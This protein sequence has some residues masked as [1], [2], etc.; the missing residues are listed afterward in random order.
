[1][2]DYFQSQGYFTRHNVK[3]LPRKDHPEFD[4]K[5]D[6][7]HSNIDV[8]GIHPRLSG[9]E[10]VM[11]VSC[12]SWQAGFDIKAKLEQLNANKVVSGREAWRGFRELMSPKW[13][14]AFIAKVKELTGADQFTY[15]TAVTSLKGDPKDW[16][17]H[18]PFSEAMGGSPIKLLPLNKMLKAL[19]ESLKTTVA[20]SDIGRTLQ[21][22]KASGCSFTFP[23]APAQ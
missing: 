20:S 4:S 3:F 21:L 8:L 18:K 22:L 14:E 9:P 12:K 17:G 11:V 10:R 19:G 2:D 16:E 7:N 13:S 23:S 15:V 6:S 5:K 1:V